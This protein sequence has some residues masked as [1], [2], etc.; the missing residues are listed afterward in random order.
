MD[1]DEM[2]YHDSQILKGKRPHTK[3]YLGND[4]YDYAKSKNFNI[5]D[6]LNFHYRS[7]S[8]TLYEGLCHFVCVI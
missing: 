1:L 7:H 2:E 3:M 6:N 5:G 4:W 8:K